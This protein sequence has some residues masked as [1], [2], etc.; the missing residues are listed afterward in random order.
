MSDRYPNLRAFARASLHEDLEAEH[1]T[2]EKALDAFLEAASP[3]ERRGIAREARAL[4]R[5]IEGWPVA[6][7]RALL[8]EEL[9]CAWWPAR[10]REVKELLA[11][12]EGQ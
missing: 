11:R 9:G 7:V 1:G 12:A 10:A 8:A 2:P 6:R 4:A 5:R 3:V